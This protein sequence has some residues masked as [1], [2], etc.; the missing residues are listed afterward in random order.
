MASHIC[1]LPVRLC[2]LFHVTYTRLCPQATLSCTNS[3]GPGPKRSSPARASSASGGGALA[4]DEELTVRSRLQGK[5]IEH[6]NSETFLSSGGRNH[7]AMFVSVQQFNGD[8]G[9]TIH[10]REHVAQSVHP[11]RFGTLFERSWSKGLSP[12]FRFA[13][14]RT[15]VTVSHHPAQRAL[16]TPCLVSSVLDWRLAILT[17]LHTSDSRSSASSFFSFQRGAAVT[18]STRGVSKANGGSS[19]AATT[20]IASS[21][22]SGSAESSPKSSRNARARSDAPC[23][24]SCVDGVSVGDWSSSMTWPRV[25]LKRVLAMSRAVAAPTMSSHDAS[26][27]LTNDECRAVAESC[28][29][30]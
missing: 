20:D 26:L 18:H 19:A 1:L 13:I 4:A 24:L 12:C 27:W 8:H 29:E 9:L 5:N 21:G 15:L 6:V 30:G 16:Q 28:P 23:T 22:T 10:R 25:S 3:S 14:V 7:Q 17:F 11:Q 2:Y